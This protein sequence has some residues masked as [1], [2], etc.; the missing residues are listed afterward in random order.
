MATGRPRSGLPPAGSVRR[1]TER[2]MADLRRAGASVSR[3]AYVDSGGDVWRP[4]VRG[5]GY[6]IVYRLGSASTIP[7]RL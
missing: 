5:R 4:I 7:A 6:V 1:L 3:G 2:E